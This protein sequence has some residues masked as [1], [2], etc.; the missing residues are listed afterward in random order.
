MIFSLGLFTR[1]RAPTG[2]SVVSTWDRAIDRLKSLYRRGEPRTGFCPFTAEELESTYTCVL[3][4]DVPDTVV[5]GVFS[6]DIS[7]FT[8]EPS[9]LTIC[10]LTEPLSVAIFSPFMVML[11][12][13][14]RSSAEEVVCVI[15]A[16]RDA[17]PSSVEGAAF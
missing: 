11:V 14:E 2:A 7:T 5:L 15:E 1:S 9:L 16:E 4:V 17:A 13:L 8:S 6:M 10:L 3:L 12:F